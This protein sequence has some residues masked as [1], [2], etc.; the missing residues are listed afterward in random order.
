MKVRRH[1]TPK[2]PQRPRRRSLRW[3]WLFVLLAAALGYLVTV[4]WLYPAPVVAT[5]RPAPSV[6]GHSRTD[7][8]QRLTAQGFRGRVIE[9]E[10]HPTLEPGAVVWQDPPPG[11]S[12]VPGAV[13][14]L[15]L[16]TGPPSNPVPDVVG[17]EASLARAVLEGVGFRVGSLDSIAAHADPGT[18]VATRPQAGVARPPG[19]RL[20]LVVSRGPANIPVPNLV[21]LTHRDAW[22]LVEAAGLRVGRVTR[23]AVAEG[24]DGRIIDQRP[25]PG[26][27]APLGGRVNIV[28]PR[29]GRP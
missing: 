1:I 24:E 27:L 28:F 19:T 9:T 16:S 25:A 5:D 15:T 12:L 29:T 3:G 10:T 8:L 22:E 6:L 14:R 21:G 23:R 18:V 11:V 4:V 13:V 7:A 2:R 20:T 26:T 17:L